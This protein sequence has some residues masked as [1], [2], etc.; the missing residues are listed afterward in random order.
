[1]E[2]L[3]MEKV[4]MNVRIKNIPNAGHTKVPVIYPVKDKNGGEDFDPNKKYDYVVLFENFENEDKRDCFLQQFRGSIKDYDASILILSVIPFNKAGHTVKTGKK[5]FYIDNVINLQKYIK[6]H[7]YVITTGSSLYSVSNGDLRVD[8]FY[9]IVFNKTYFYSPILKSYVFPVDAL[10]L[11]MEPTMPNRRRCEW[12]TI[13]TFEYF[14]ADQQ[15]KAIKKRPPFPRIPEMKI[16]EITNFDQFY[17]DHAGET[18][19]ALDTETDG[20]DCFKNKIGY[21]SL[22]FDG[23]TGYYGEWKNVDPEKFGAFVKGKFQIYQNGKFD[24]KL[25]V[26]HGISRNC[27]KISFD[28]WNGGHILNEMRSNSLKTL[29]WLYTN[30]G[31]YDKRLDDYVRKHK[32]TNYLTIPR[33]IIAPYSAIDAIVTYLCWVEMEKQITKID[34]MKLCP[35]WPIRRYFNEI[36]MCT[37]NNFIDVELGGAH[38]NV[39]LLKEEQENLA[40]DLIDVVL[41]IWNNPKFGLQGY[42]EFRSP[43]GSPYKIYDDE[44]LID[45]AVFKR[46]CDFLN[47]PKKFGLFL[48]SKGYPR[49]TIGK[50]EYYLSGKNDLLDWIHEG[51]DE[52]ELIR[53]YRK[54]QK[55][56][57]SYVGT[58][59]EDGMFKF[60]IDH[61]DGSQRVHSTFWVML[62]KSHRFSSREPNLQQIPKHAE[63]AKRIRRLFCP[64]S[65]DYYIGEF[66]AAGFQLRIGA[67]LSG[68]VE[69]KRVFTELGGDMHSMTA[70][71]VLK[72]DMELEEFLRRKK[73]PEL[74]RARFKSKAINFGFEFGSS[75]FAFAK[76]TLMQEWTK[77]DILAYIEEHDLE[78][79][80]DQLRKIK[81]D[82]DIVT[83]NFLN[84]WAV[85]ADIRKKFFDR[86]EGLKAWVKKVPEDAEKNGYVISQFGAI[87]RLPQ[88]LHFGKDGKTRRSR[89][90]KEFKNKSLNS[91]VQNFEI[92]LITILINDLM[93]YIKDNNLKSRVFIT[94]HD[95]TVLYVYKTELKEITE[96]AK[97]IFERDIPENNGIPMELEGIISTYS[98]GEAWGSGFEV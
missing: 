13:D 85:A 25:M 7:S 68:D 60:L 66:D 20:L 36:V 45:K 9:D 82:D 74:D 42:K 63:D 41:K 55:F 15:F 78:D 11:W 95:S 34:A 32:I 61:E 8:N 67:A 26:N 54:Y 51:Y 83:E 56:I 31:G 18:H 87:R 76:D 72:R 21:F 90:Y 52:I 93:D 23:K 92:V 1:M 40:N 48:E 39:E 97:E 70:V 58:T 4:P 59:E 43:L 10:Y 2:S 88:L 30:Y 17:K 84:Y 44:G 29:A 89:D 50:G 16:E 53:T 38:I 14:F 46:I 94:V 75:A 6:P 69:M 65:D 47:S 28:T 86:Y 79:K 12:R 5:N 3:F 73:E 98:K 35:N 33:N 77:E 81:M 80:K 37:L 62:T 91:P 96:V 24:I 27:L 71:S 57:D 49:H 22:S 19:I 64:P